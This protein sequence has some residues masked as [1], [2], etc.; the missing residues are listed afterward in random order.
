M[1]WS[2]LLV[3]IVGAVLAVWLVLLGILYVA[4]RDR[5]RLRDALRLLP[6]LVRMLTRLARDGSVPRW[7]RVVVLV[8]LAYLASPI[9]LVPDVLPGIGY[10]DDIILVA[11]VLRWVVAAAGP[12]AVD[13][14]WPGT[15]EG[16]AAVLMLIGHSRE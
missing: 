10:L 8:L 2:A 4:G 9:D 14:C 11:L 16:K 15:P 6:D 12:D 13:R 1:Q 5:I 3:G 7:L